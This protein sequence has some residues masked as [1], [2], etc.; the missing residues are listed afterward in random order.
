MITHNLYF[1]NERNVPLLRKT[2]GIISLTEQH[3]KGW[4]FYFDMCQD[5]VKNWFNLGI[6]LSILSLHNYINK[7]LLEPTLIYI[8]ICIT[9]IM[10]YN[11][12]FKKIN[13]ALCQN[14]PPILPNI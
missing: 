5:M 13:Y 6:V 1:M 7:L 11:H 2:I 14:I 3:I 9:C 10:T 4:V 12:E 8:N